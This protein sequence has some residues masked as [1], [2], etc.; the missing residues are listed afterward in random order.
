MV[1]TY[2]VSSL[3]CRFLSSSYGCQPPSDVRPMTMTYSSWLASSSCQSTTQQIPASCTDPFWWYRNQ[4]DY[5]YVASPNLPPA[6]LIS[7][8]LPHRSSHWKRTSYRSRFHCYHHNLTSSD[9]TGAW[10]SSP[11]IVSQDAFGFWTRACLLF[12][13]NIVPLVDVTNFFVIYY[14]Y[15]T[16]DVSVPTLITS[17]L[18]L[19]VCLRSL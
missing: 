13:Q 6:T 17:P 14:L 1:V 11:Q 9:E 4:Q 2:N 16:L 10:Y 19:A 15:I 12:W 5:R 7:L 3:V 18:W 8:D